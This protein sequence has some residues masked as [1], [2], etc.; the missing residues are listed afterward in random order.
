M[1][2]TWWNATKEGCV[3]KTC[4]PENEEDV[5]RVILGEKKAAA[6]HD[7]GPYGRCLPR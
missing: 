5:G 1:G 7:R 3:S 4:L 2:T 6:H